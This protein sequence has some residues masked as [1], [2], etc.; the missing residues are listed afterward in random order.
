MPPNTLRFIPAL[1]AAVFAVLLLAPHFGQGQD[2][3]SAL[4]EYERFMPGVTVPED[5]S[6]DGMA[7]FYDTVQVLCRVEGG[8]YCEHG[9]VVAR[10]GVIVHTTFF[11]CDFPVAYLVAQYGRYEEVRRYRRVL[12]LRWPHAYAHVRRSGW[13][14][15][16]EPV[17]IVTWWRPTKP[18][19]QEG[20]Y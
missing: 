17:Y 5:V 3:G 6:C 15:S 12:V 11:R 19:E 2:A 20:S 8:P 16:M 14:N 1:A 4:A 18:S 7:G 13:M 9:Y 10:R